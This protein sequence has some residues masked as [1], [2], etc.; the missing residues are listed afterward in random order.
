DNREP[1]LRVPLPV[2]LRPPRQLVAQRSIA[3]HRSHADE[4]ERGLEVAHTNGEGL[5]HRLDAVV[6]LQTGVPN[7]IPQRSRH[8]ADVAPATMQE[9]DVNVA[10]GSEFTAPIAADR[11]E[12]DVVDVTE[13]VRQ[14]TIDERPI[15]SSE[16]AALQSV[17]LNERGALLDER[18]VIVKARRCP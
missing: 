3:G 4:S 15:C 12:R 13:Q 16:V 8:V 18:L 7:R 5:L 14:P 11:Y 2:V 10:S 9:D 6:E 1:P 17:V